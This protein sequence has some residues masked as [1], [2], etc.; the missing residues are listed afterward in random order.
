MRTTIRQQTLGLAFF[1]AIASPAAAAENDKRSIVGVDAKLLSDP[2]KYRPTGE[3]VAFGSI[4]DVLEEKKT[5]NGWHAKIRLVGE[6]KPLGWIETKGNLGHVKEFDPS[7]KP[8]DAVALVDSLSGL[9]RLM[10][11]MYNTRGR[12]LKERAKEL[13]AA[14]ADL[15]AVLRVESSGRAF[16]DDGHPIMRFENHVFYR[17][18]GEKHKDVFD[19][20]FTFDQKTRYKNH[21]FRKNPEAV[22]SAFHLDNRKEREVLAFARNLDDTAALLSA[23]YGAAQVM[24]F[25]HRKIGYKDVQSMYQAFNAGIKPQLDG[26]IAYI[27]A[28]PLCMEGLK[29]RDYFKFATGYNGKGKENDYAPKIKAAAESYAKVTKGKK[30]VE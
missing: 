21:T 19:R 25:N 26:M 11:A 24:G 2:P 30:E 7:M 20:H 9:D 17:N 16:D 6:S 8:S 10:A 13:G 28:T 29:N 12:Y 3:R 18:W 14:P 4:V 23:S 5:L 27:K 15:A 22:R 1:L